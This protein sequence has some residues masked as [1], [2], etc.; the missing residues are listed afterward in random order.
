M[1]YIAFSCLV[2]PLMEITGA[3]YLY[4]LAYP[5][6]MHLVGFLRSAAVVLLTMWIV[7]QFT[8]RKIFWKA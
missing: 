7:G 8:K 4:R 6:G 3:I 2:Q 1:C 5:E